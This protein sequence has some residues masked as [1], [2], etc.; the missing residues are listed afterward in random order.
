MHK[1]RE[2][3]NDSSIDNFLKIVLHHMKMDNI[4]FE[5]RVGSAGAGLFVGCGAGEDCSIK[6][7]NIQSLFLKIYRI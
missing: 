4:P 3:L 5:F 2:K 7:I 6:S 1:R